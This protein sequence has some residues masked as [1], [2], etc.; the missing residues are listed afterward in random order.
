MKQE[1]NKTNIIDVEKA[2]MKTSIFAQAK[3]EMAHQKVCNE[4]FTFVME[5]ENI[6]KVGCQVQFQVFAV[7]FQELL[8]QSETKL[9][10]CQA[11]PGYILPL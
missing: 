7:L 1:A 2:Y 8:C 4:Y 10:P 9:N 5:I 3:A 6:V 11:E